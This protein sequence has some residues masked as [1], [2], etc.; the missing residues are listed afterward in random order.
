MQ[1]PRE[2]SSKMLGALLEMFYSTRF[3]FFLFRNIQKWCVAIQSYLDT[4]FVHLP[5]ATWRHGGVP[6]SDTVGQVKIVCCLLY[7]ANEEIYFPFK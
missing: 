3:R 5:N 6:C 4:P 7:G 1:E 2:I